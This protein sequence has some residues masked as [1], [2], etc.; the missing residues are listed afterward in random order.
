MLKMPSLP[1]CSRQIAAGL[2]LLVGAGLAGCAGDDF[3]YGFSRV[4]AGNEGLNTPPADYRND[5]LAIAHS[6]LNNPRRIR[7]ASIS[8][9]VLKNVG[10]RGE[11]Y[12]VCVRFNAMNTDG[13][14]TG[15]KSR[16][17][18][19]R[20]GKLDQFAEAVPERLPDQKEDAPD[21]CK[22]VA[23]Q[24]FPELEKLGP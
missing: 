17:A 13:K 14:Y 7:E 4:Q 6:Y 16:I 8:E 19:Y 24:P 12:V 21:P 11:R 15:L 18:I 2:L 9:P 22:E 3:R 23:M 20:R 5:I 10:G 1:N